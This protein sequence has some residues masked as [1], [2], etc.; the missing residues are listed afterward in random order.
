MKFIH[1]GDCHLGSWR[2]PE[3]N[4]LNF[5]SFQFVI[6]TCIKEK[7]EFVLISGDLFDSAYPSIETLK[8]SFDEFRKLKEARIP[9]FL[10][11]GSHDYSASG[12]TFLD[13]LSKAGFCHNVS[14]FEENDGKLILLPTVYNEVA[15]FGY[16]GKKSGL[17]VKELENMKLQDAPGLYKILMLHTAIKDAAPNPNIKST[18]ENKLP[19]VDYLALSHLHIN[20]NKNN[21]V[22]SGPTFPNSL[23]ELE[24][25]Q[26]GSFYIVESGVPQKREIILKKVFSLNLEVKNALNAT[27]E[28]IRH[29]QN[30]NIIDKI[31]ILKLYGILDVGKTSDIDF[32][33]LEETAMKHGAHVF[34][35]STSR[36]H[37][38]QP[39]IKLDL[40][41]SQNLEN[42]IIKN[43][44]E[45]NPSKFNK[46]I[47]GLIQSLQVEKND[48]EK[49][50]TF[51]E[52]ILSEC[53][54]VLE[55]K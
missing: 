39:E 19:K 1:L 51:D 54:K 21:R 7:V 49:T 6:K 25:L 33:K 46:L 17:E 50:I 37:M 31:V 27:D 38:A 44:E 41:D 52:R 13:V 18:D 32:L 23:L 30:E 4:K 53:K 35:K 36:L 5:Q 11:A 12:K 45:S 34:I 9:V 10:I 8:E 55:I 48:D 3:L 16:P 15:I 40:L 24:E 47:N 43:Y 20:Y 22:Y 42:Q 14:K 2:Q 28:V 26:A 29:L